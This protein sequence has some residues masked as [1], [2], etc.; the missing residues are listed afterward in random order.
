MIK[1]LL[2]ALNYVLLTMET[3][4]NLYLEFMSTKAVCKAEEVRRS[5]KN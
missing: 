5:K 3:A 4:G 1:F 2:N